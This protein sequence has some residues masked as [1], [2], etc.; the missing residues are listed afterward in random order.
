VIDIVAVGSGVVEV[1]VRG[2]LEMQHAPH[3]RESVL[4]LLNRG[5]VTGVNLD[6]AAVT[7]LDATGAGAIIVVHRIATHRR[8]ALRITAVSAAVAQIMSLVGAAA[9]LPAQVPDRPADRAGTATGQPGAT[10]LPVT[11]SSSHPSAPC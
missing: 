8:V 6:L 4:A 5:D 9:L 11:T 1:L 2:D 10:G 7:L 3:L